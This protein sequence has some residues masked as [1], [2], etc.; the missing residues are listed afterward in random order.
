MNAV[1]SLIRCGVAMCVNAAVPAGDIAD[2]VNGFVIFFVVIF[3]QD[4][5]DV[6]GC[7]TFQILWVAVRFFMFF[8]EMSVVIFGLAFGMLSDFLELYYIINPLNLGQYDLN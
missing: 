7:G 2:K 1:I 8:T 6:L 5:T 3:H 4:T